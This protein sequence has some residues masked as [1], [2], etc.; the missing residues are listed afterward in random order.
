MLDG[1]DVML[2]RRARNKRAALGHKE[3]RMGK[4]PPAPERG[5]GGEARGRQRRGSLHVRNLPC[6][7]VHY[8][9]HIQ[10]VACSR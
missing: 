9:F 1:R 7:P 5:G 8:N 3:C 6:Q 4:Q 10:I 2:S